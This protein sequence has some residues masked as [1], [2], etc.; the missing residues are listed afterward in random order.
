MHF[1]GCQN[2]FAWRGYQSTSATFS[3]NNNRRFRRNWG[4]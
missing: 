3:R 4:I 1:I 2:L